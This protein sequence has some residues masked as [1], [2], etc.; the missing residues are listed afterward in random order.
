LWLAATRF[1]PDVRLGIAAV[2]IGVGTVVASIE[3][4]FFREMLKPSKGAGLLGLAMALLMIAATY[5]VY[6]LLAHALPWG[7]AST[8]ALYVDTLHVPHPNTVVLLVVALIVAGEELLWRGVVQ[9][10]IQ[11]RLGP[12]WGVPVSAVV[13]GLSHALIGSTLLTV[14]A[15]ICGL[16]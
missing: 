1:A 11:N 5:P 7:A 8:A 16:F 4:D 10:A 13:Y 3:R 9:E 15:V 12:R 6:P 14:V 2:A